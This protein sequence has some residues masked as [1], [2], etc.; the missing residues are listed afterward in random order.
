MHSS[1]IHLDAEAVSL[2]SDHAE[3]FTR[4]SDIDGES[5]CTEHI[6]TDL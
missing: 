2:T 6:E 3:D 5:R 1:L 4:R